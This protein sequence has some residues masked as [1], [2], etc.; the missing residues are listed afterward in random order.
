[1]FDRISKTPLKIQ[2]QPQD[3]FYKRGALKNFAKFAGKHLCRNIFLNKVVGL[4]HA[5]LLKKR[6]RHWCFPVFQDKPNLRWSFM[7]IPNKQLVYKISKC[8]YCDCLPPQLLCFQSWSSVQCY[9][10]SES[11]FENWKLF[12][13]N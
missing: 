1:M 7:V 2:K 8:I 9:L 6:R 3:V 10:V 12:V 4:R 11:I 13:A 5:I